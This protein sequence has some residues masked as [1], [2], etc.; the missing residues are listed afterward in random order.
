MGTP[1]RY[2]QAWLDAGGVEHPPA[3][4]PAPARVVSLVPSLTESFAA[5]GGRARLAG[6]TA[7][8]IRPAGLLRIRASR[9]SAGPRSSA[10]R[11]SSRSSRTW[12][13]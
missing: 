9:S 7:F 5:L 13:C 2:A 10:A 4:S 3:G 8:C 11:S 6:I 12:C 1:A